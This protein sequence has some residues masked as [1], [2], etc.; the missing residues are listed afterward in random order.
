[1]EDLLEKKV[2]E[3]KALDQDAEGI[4]D[5]A[6]IYFSLLST[7]LGLS[8]LASQ[9]FFLLDLGTVVRKYVQ[10][11]FR[12]P[13]SSCGIKIA[14]SPVGFMFPSSHSVLRYEV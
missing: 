13:F 3:N 10:V 14:F 6:F 2:R 12:R 5:S 11:I 8:F 4:W 9:A 1:L 7:D